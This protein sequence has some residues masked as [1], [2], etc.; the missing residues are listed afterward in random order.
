L[1]AKT[2]GVPFVTEV[3]IYTGDHPGLFSQLAGAVAM[4]GA[5]I[6]DA[7]IFHDDGR[8]GARFV[9]DQD[10]DGRPLGDARRIQRLRET[11]ARRALRESCRGR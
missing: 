2:D 3:S 5:N 1:T 11:I 4:C 9:L 7:K 10:S 8:H 6:V